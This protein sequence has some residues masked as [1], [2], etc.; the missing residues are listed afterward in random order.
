MGVNFW[1]LLALVA[2]LLVIAYLLAKLHR[3]RDQLCLIKDALADIKDGNLNRR[4]LARES[5]LTK[6]ICYDINEIAMSGQT[7]LIQ[8]KRRAHP[9]PRVPCEHDPRH[10]RPPQ[11]VTLLYRTSKQAVAGPAL[12][13]KTT[14]HY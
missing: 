11:G 7:Q 5:D 2:A 10:G 13:D 1:L 8:Q 6:Q 4:V 14:L 3:V 12:E 9:Q